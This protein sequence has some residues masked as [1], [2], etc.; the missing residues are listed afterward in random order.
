MFLVTVIMFSSVFLF[1]CANEEL[2]VSAEE[3]AS[4]DTGYGEAT[5][6]SWKDIELVD[7]NY[8]DSFTVSGLLDKPVLFETF[9]VWCPLCTKQ[10]GII[11]ELHHDSEVGDAF[12]SV[13]VNID[14]NEDEALVLEHAQSNGFDWR[15]AVAPVTLTERL[16]ELY[17]VTIASA[18]QAP[19]VVVCPNGQSKLLK[20]GVKSADE[21]KEG[22]AFCG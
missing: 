18:P 14:P 19:I 21:L 15:Y 6:S 20:G 16:V 3:E 22:L 13:T 10:Q 5:E 4:L 1:G 9:A 2:V 7:V 12:V 8:G 17:G 11:S